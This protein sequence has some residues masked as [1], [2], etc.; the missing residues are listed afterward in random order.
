MKAKE[1]CIAAL[2]LDNEPFVQT[3][4]SFPFLLI[5]KVVARCSDNDAKGQFIVSQATGDLS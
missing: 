1:L 2:D 3:G 5:D 4:R